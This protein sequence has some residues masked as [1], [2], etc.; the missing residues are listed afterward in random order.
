[1][2]QPPTCLTRRGFLST[3]ASATAFSIMTPALAFGSA[4]NSR[5][6]VGAVGVGGR[7]GW[8]ADHVAK[9][10]GFQVTAV[11][12]Y[13]PPIAQAA[14]ERLKAPKER[15]FAGL[16]GYRQ[17]LESKVDA[18]FLET[19][20]YFFPAHAQAAVAAGCHVYVAKPVAVDVPGCLLIRELGKR[21]TA[22]K[23]VF[24]VDF[25]TRADPFHQ[26]AIQ[27]VHAGMIGKVGLLTA[28]Y[29]DEC[30]LDPPRQKTVENLL[31]G[32]AWVNDTALG[33]AYIVN[34][35]IHAIDV[36]LWIAGD[37][38]VSA[39]GYSCRNR[40]NANGDSH[41][42]YAV[43]YQFKSGLV[44]TDQSEHV[45]NASGFKAGCHAYGQEG[46][47]ETNYAGKVFIRGLQDGYAGGENKELYADGMRRNVDTFHQ[48]I[49]EGRYDNPTVEPS[50]NSTLATILGREAALKA[51]KLTWEELLKDKRRLEVDLTGLKA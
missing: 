35:D 14:G 49:T 19:P 22:N 38:P 40:P 28:F 46:Y 18:V 25:Q 42:C 1:M 5:V 50:V 16:N 6:T 30:F 32:L 15:C 10:P 26:E 8:I 12:D 9:H 37:A 23:K 51:R 47:L 4:A 41:D 31:S 48:C 34:C 17:L 33:G 44:M 27:K 20:P 11:A 21:S 36:A 24:L 13:F 45:R 39:M 29:H 3:T 7:G 43:S 2:N